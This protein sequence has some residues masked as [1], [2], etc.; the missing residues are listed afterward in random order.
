MLRIDE[1]DFKVFVRSILIHPIRIQYSQVGALPADTFFC[2][3]TQRTLVFELVH[4]LVGLYYQHHSRY[5]K[6]TYRFAVSGSL[7]DGTF[8]TSSS[9][10]DAVDDIALFCLVS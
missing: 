9:D 10:T 4:S 5:K 3:R 8:A 1:D 7:G 2:R 6:G